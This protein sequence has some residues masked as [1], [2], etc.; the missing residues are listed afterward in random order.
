MALDKTLNL[1]QNKRQNAPKDP[2]IARRLRL[3]TRIKNQ[4]DLAERDLR[5][6]Q[7]QRIFR[8]LA[9]WWWQEGTNWFL[10]IQYCRRPLELAKGKWAIQCEGLEGIIQGLRSVEKA[11]LAGEFDSQ[12]MQNAERTRANFKS[13]KAA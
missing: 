12:I 11:I 7:S 13:R 4:I 8:R 9:K 10:S 1:V 3:I 5:G 6:E 2:I